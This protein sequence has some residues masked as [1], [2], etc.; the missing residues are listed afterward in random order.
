FS[1]GRAYLGIPDFPRT[2]AYLD[3]A[4]AWQEQ[5]PD[6]VF[7]LRPQLYYYLGYYFD[8]IGDYEQA[9]AQNHQAI[10]WYRQSADMDSTGLASALNALGVNH[11][12]M[13]RND[14]ARY[15][16]AQALALR[17]QLGNPVHIGETTLN[18]GN[19][20]L[21][22]GLWEKARTFYQEA[23]A[24]FEE[25]FGP[26]HYYVAVTYEN[27]GISYYEEGLYEQARVYLE[28][29]LNMLRTLFGQDHPHLI[30]L[31]LNLGA[32]YIHKE[33]GPQARQY[34]L[35]A[36]ALVKRHLDP[37]HP[38]L[39]NLYNNLA[40]VLTS[41]DEWAQA[42]HY[43]TE[44]RRIW[45][46]QFDEPNSVLLELYGGQAQGLWD[47]GKWREAAAYYR[48]ALGTMQSMGKGVSPLAPTLYREIAD[49]YLGLGRADSAYH[50][51]R[52]AI[53]SQVPFP[54]GRQVPDLPP[55]QTVPR[56]NELIYS[57]G[58]MGKILTHWGPG[59][60]ADSS[61]ALVYLGLAV[62]LID[63]M[64]LIGNGRFETQLSRYS[65]PIYA[66]GV[67]L[68]WARWAQTGDPAFREAGFRFAERNKAASLY[69]ALTK[70]RARV[71]AGVPD[72][73][74]RYER[75][76][77][78]SMA[79]L[80]GEIQQERERGPETDT[81]ALRHWNRRL[82]QLVRTKD[83]LVS[84][85]AEAYPNYYQLRYDTGVPSLADLQGQLFPGQ[86]LLSYFWADSLAWTWTITREGIAWRT[87]AFA[88]GL[89]D[90]LDTWVSAIGADLDPA[91]AWAPFVRQSHYLYEH[92]L[93][94]VLP[95]NQGTDHLLIIPDGPLGR[96]P[97]ALLLT[98][99]AD[100]SQ[101][102][103][104]G[105]LPYLLRQQAVSYIYSARLWQPLPQR[106][107]G[108]GYAGFAPT[109][110]ATLSQS[111]RSLE[112]EAF[113]FGPL[114]HNQPEIEA[115]AQLLGGETFIGAEASEATF[116]TQ[117]P[118]YALLHL[119]MHA[120]AHPHLPDQ[121]G[122]VFTLPTPPDSADEAR[123]KDLAEEADDGI[124]HAY[125]IYGL[126]LPAH[127]AVL[128]ACHTGIGQQ[129]EGEGIMSLARAF[130]YAGC[131][132]LMP[133]LWAVD[134]AATR[135]LME[136]FF[137]AI[138]QGSRPSQAL[139]QSQLSYARRFPQA[140]PRYWGAFVVIGEDAP[141]ERQSV[142]W[143]YLILIGASLLGAGG[144][145]LARKR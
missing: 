119:A 93:G 114:R 34:F 137:A 12:N 86:A 26:E 8:E 138:Q 136:P 48:Q 130:A 145:W 85:L 56:L 124:L 143:I 3:S 109:Y 41:L 2:L 113:A 9:A 37:E 142:P 53:R 118:R 69:L 101:E 63:S 107:P 31:Y 115:V 133:T 129:V 94:P 99:Q 51:A 42:E 59:G 71:F 141:L 140:H 33:K 65:Q 103:R 92:L 58:E 30:N 47:Q 127:L 131:Q 106:R 29:S 25:A 78:Q 112:G 36:E 15:Y 5:H 46:R 108:Q 144:W 4:R 16:L 88:P 20:W 39:C 83:S 38:I 84:H 117:A 91:D 111:M 1:L 70:S 72:T 50:F 80:R 45:F 49:A 35:E 62:D 110:S 97:F 13:G 132:S 67:R 102:G 40:L 123:P 134:D 64:R 89:S 14:S 125:E 11:F 10:A 77:D 18:L 82:L 100:D 28:Q 79:H 23:S 52:E 61:V 105:D 7:A 76:L 22:S 17:Q 104:Y 90:S 24:R 54:P 121:S 96:L 139:R 126:S 19:T 98:D 32:L 128:S 81:L 95:D 57:L 122:M 60:Q 66:L 116:K 74:L 75:A 44:G 21:E 120:Y 68:A 43:F 87:L 135:D 55:L 6:Q 73:L 27:I